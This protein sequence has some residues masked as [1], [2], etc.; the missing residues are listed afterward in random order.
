[1]SQ[2][3]VVRSIAL[4]AAVALALP[5]AAHATFPGQNGKLAYSVASYDKAAKEN[6]FVGPGALFTLNSATVG[7]APTALPSDPDATEFEPA[8]SPNGAQIAYGSVS[9]GKLDGIY[10]RDAASTA[11]PR[12]IAKTSYPDTPSWT[13]DGKTVVFADWERGIMAVPADGSADPRLLIRHPKRWIAIAPTVTPDGKTI[14]FAR[15]K[16]TKSPKQYRSEIVATDISGANLR[17]LLSSGAKF[18]L[19]HLPDVSPDG[20]SIVF[21]ATTP[22][23]AGGLYV[24]GIDGAKPALLAASPRTGYLSAPTWSP[25]GQRVAATLYGTSIKRG[26]SIVTVDVASGKLTTLRQQKKA[27]L[28]NLSWQ[29]LPL[30]T[31]PAATAG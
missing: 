14:V 11:A 23:G 21:E 29:S 18:A 6:F 20:S 28:T 27:F 13:P 10:V 3:S 31:P 7:A 26:S 22:T 12:L 4:S 30:P 25:D 1:M 19:P 17:R 9:G 5:A 24:A 2:R 15:Q 8:W 16:I